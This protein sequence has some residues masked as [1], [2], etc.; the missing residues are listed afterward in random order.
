[1]YRPDQLGLCCGSLVQADFRGLAEA[2]ASAGFRTISMWPTLFNAA[3]ESGLSEQDLRTIL[4]DNKLSITEIDPLCSWLP[5][6]PANAGLAGPFAAYSAD[7]FFHIADT[8]GAT[9][10]NVIQTTDDTLAKQEVI[11]HLSALCE[12][13]CSHDLTVSVEFLPWSPISNLQSALD[14]VKATGQVNCGVNIDIWHHFRSGGN[15][16]QLANL[17][18]NLIAAMQFNDVAA[19]PLDNILEETATSR[20]LPGQGSSDSVSVLKALWQSGVRVPLSVEVFNAELMG[21]PAIEAAGRLGD[22][23]RAVLAQATD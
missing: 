1:M 6:D 9:T 2:A 17:D 3:L 18:S 11:D 15:V 21:L 16:E 10:L 22:S 5:I 13:A 8:L 14:L 19:Q 12:R 23:I 7:D 4:A 20:L